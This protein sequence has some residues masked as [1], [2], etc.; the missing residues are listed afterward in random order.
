MSKLQSSNADPEH[1][2]SP[3]QVSPTPSEPKEA[4]PAPVPPPAQPPA[5]PASSDPL[6]PIPPGPPCYQVG[7]QVPPFMYQPL[8]GHYPTL[9]QYIPG[10][11]SV[12]PP[13]QIPGQEPPPSSTTLASSQAKN[14]NQFLSMPP[15]PPPT[16]GQFSDPGWGFMSPGPGL[17]YSPVMPPQMWPPSQHI[18]LPQPQ[19]PQKRKMEDFI[20]SQVPSFSEVDNQTAVK[21]QKLCGGT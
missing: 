20:T 4:T 15:P 2:S 21:R 19:Q 13:P 10:V 5:P 11:Q 9:P 1:S 18:F 8:P 6:L 14:M 12:Q 7:H 17:L 16:G 3:S